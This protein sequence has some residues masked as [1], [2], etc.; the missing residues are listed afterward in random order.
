MKYYTG[1]PSG[2]SNPNE[3]GRTDQPPYSIRVRRDMND[4]E[5]PGLEID[6]EKREISFDWRGMY[7]MFYREEN[8]VDRNIK[9][10][11]TQARTEAL[12][13]KAMMD[14]GGI[15][16]IDAMQRLLKRVKTSEENARRHARRKRLDTIYKAHGLKGFNHDDFPEQEEETLEYLAQGRKNLDWYEMSDESDGDGNEDEDEGEDEGSEQEWEDMDVDE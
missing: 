4:T 9:E 16:L 14:T 3:L 10:L 15:S 2:S 13:L 6:Y 12:D 7:N 8:Y 1:P 11:A 5:I